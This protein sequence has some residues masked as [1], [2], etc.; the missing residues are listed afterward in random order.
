MSLNTLK[1]LLISLQSTLDWYS[2]NTSVDTQLTLD[3]HLCQQS[4]E[5]QMIFTDMPSSVEWYIS[6]IQHSTNLS[7]WPPMKSWLGVNLDFDWVPTK[8]W[9][10]CPLSVHR[11]VDQL[12]VHG[13]LNV[14]IDCDLTFDTFDTT[15][16]WLLILDFWLPLTSYYRRKTLSSMLLL[17]KGF[18]YI[19]LCMDKM[20]LILVTNL[21]S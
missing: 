1:W 19:V 8:Y 16:T 20:P 2:I 3:W 12:V 7:D 17:A 10:S 21:V 14:L 4:V 11:Y 6:V 13:H 15:V 9:L 18:R 5:S